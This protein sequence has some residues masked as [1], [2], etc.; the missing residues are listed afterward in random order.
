MKTIEVDEQLYNYI[1]GQTQHIGE[2]ASDILRRLLLNEN[3]MPDNSCEPT[4][5]GIAH[6]NNS[7]LPKE[8]VLACG[9]TNDKVLSPKPK[10]KT[11]SVKRPRSKPRKSS[12]RKTE[13]S[14]L[15]I[16]DLSLAALLQS[17][18]FTS[19]ELSISRF[20]MIL[21]VLYKEQPEKF[22][23]A[24][25]IKGKKRSYFSKDQQKLA[26]AGRTTKPRAIPNT[27]Y[28]VISNVNAGRKC[29]ILEQLMKS[30]TFN[31]ALINQACQ[32][33]TP[34]LAE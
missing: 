14:N 28:W 31:A 5:S 29:L 26:K 1:A 8:A 10:K 16:P 4:L 7:N 3:K 13:S 21:S 12:G 9:E 17:S 18:E 34:T 23:L 30:M 6:S 24:C 15:L 27:P 20:L 22:A 2:N 33:L 32:S 19:L 25:E 11:S